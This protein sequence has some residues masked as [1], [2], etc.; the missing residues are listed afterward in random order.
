MDGE[1]DGG[2]ETRPAIVY[3]D[4]LHGTTLVSFIL[5]QIIILLYSSS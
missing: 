1:D 5:K 3:P 4:I 2:G